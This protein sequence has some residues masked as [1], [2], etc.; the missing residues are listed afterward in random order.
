M[1]GKGQK[2]NFDVPQV[3]IDELFDFVLQI[4]KFQLWGLNNQ[5]LSNNLHGHFFINMA[6]I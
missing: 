5:F 3:E 2:M 1:S 6:Q 4:L